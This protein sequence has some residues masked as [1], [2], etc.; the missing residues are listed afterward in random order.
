MGDNAADHVATCATLRESITSLTTPEECIAFLVAWLARGCVNA[1]AAAPGTSPPQ[2]D[3]GLPMRFF[4]CSPAGCLLTVFSDATDLVFAEQPFSRSRVSRLLWCYEI[5][6][7]D[8]Q[9]VLVYDAV[10]PAAVR[11]AQSLHSLFLPTSGQPQGFLFDLGFRCLHLLCQLGQL[12][13]PKDPTD[14]RSVFRLG[15][16]DPSLV[17][18]PVKPVGRDAMLEL[19]R[20]LLA[21]CNTPMLSKFSVFLHSCIQNNVRCLCKQLL[22]SFAVVS[23]DWA[24]PDPWAILPSFEELAAFLTVFPEADL[25]V[26][27]NDILEV[28]LAVDGHQSTGYMQEEER[29]HLDR[30]QR[31]A[32]EFDGG[33]LPLQHLLQAALPRAVA[34]LFRQA[35]VS[36]DGFLSSWQSLSRAYMQLQHASQFLAMVCDTLLLLGNLAMEQHLLHKV[37]DLLLSHVAGV[38]VADGVDLSVD[39]PGE[40]YLTLALLCSAAD[41]YPRRRLLHFEGFFFELFLVFRRH[42]SGRAGAKQCLYLCSVIASGSVAAARRLGRLCLL[43]LSCNAGGGGSDPAADS[44]PAELRLSSGGCA[45]VES[46]MQLVFCLSW[47]L[48]Q[49]GWSLMESERSA[50]VSRTLLEAVLRPADLVE[51]APSALS[52]AL[53]RRVCSECIVD[54]SVFDGLLAAANAVSPGAVSGQTGKEDAYD[55]DVLAVVSR[56]CTSLSLPPPTEEECRRRL[57]AFPTSSPPADADA[58]AD[59][60]LE[61]EAGAGGTSPVLFPFDRLN[62]SAPVPGSPV[63]LYV[64][65][66]P[67]PAV[68]LV[69]NIGPDELPPVNTTVSA[70]VLEQLPKRL[71]VD[72]PTIR[73]VSFRFDRLGSHV[74]E[75]VAAC[76]CG[77]GEEERRLDVA[78]QNEHVLVHGAGCVFRDGP[79][80]AATRWWTLWMQVAAAWV[81]DSRALSTDQRAELFA[82]LC[83]GFAILSSAA[84][85]AASSG[86]H[87]SVALS[88]GVVTG[89]PDLLEQTANV[90]TDD[91][92]VGGLWRGSMVFSGFADAFLW[93]PNYK[94]WLCRCCIGHASLVHEKEER[95]KQLKQFQDEYRS[96]DRR[97]KALRLSREAL[98]EA[99]LPDGQAVA[100]IHGFMKKQGHRRKNWKVRYALVDRYDFY[101]GKSASTPALR[102][103]RLEDVIRFG[104]WDEYARDKLGLDLMGNP[105]NCALYLEALVNGA[106]WPLLMVLE[107]EA[108]RHRWMHAFDN[109]FRLLVVDRKLTRVDQDMRA[110]RRRF[111]KSGLSPAISP[112][113]GSRHAASS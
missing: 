88:S 100:P 90:A 109:L 70:A 86:P 67:V 2:E 103:I 93:Q 46:A 64:Q 21:I 112:P 107:S 91:P 56:I 65:F 25:V 104:A 39:V 62:V 16:L 7:R 22:S 1:E 35:L 54:G 52:P 76:A 50:A 96:M 87:D 111:M 95:A 8:L 92:A 28:V 102:I 61:N 72:L 73:S 59:V 32:T 38:V 58:S 13:F 29:P 79:F 3:P 74:A 60:N 53:L 43:L 30:Q 89:L 42:S 84:T 33:Q 83:T 82:R 57:G 24:V 78:E 68:T 11:M 41:K 20:E 101:Y 97:R 48:R 44:A 98:I 5:A 66:L 80:I 17:V 69:A 12:R 9:D 6:C 4:D 47:C 55:Y 75:V 81:L 49:A 40:C 63:L 23:G 34:G 71:L 94:K 14:V 36:P 113:S 51:R 19:T 110:I 105:E 37:V 31:A 18:R 27:L 15:P 85:A 45:D 108:E 77:C 10:V 106:P 99:R 26:V